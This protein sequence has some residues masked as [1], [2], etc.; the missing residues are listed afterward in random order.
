MYY[1]QNEFF[2]LMEAIEAQEGV[3]LDETHDISHYD[4]TGKDPMPDDLR[5]IRNC[6]QSA[7]FEVPYAAPDETDE[8]KTLTVCAVDDRMGLWPRYA[9]ANAPGQG[10]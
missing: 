9:G 5:V 8:S 10:S 4:F 1:E 6:G 7:L 2:R 3:H